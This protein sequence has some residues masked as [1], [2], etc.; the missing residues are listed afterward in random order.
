[1]RHNPSLRQRL[2]SV[3]TLIILFGLL[4]G[5]SPRTAGVSV[6]IDVPLDGLIL[7]GV[8]AINIDGHAAS[9]G[10]ISRIEIWIDGALLANIESP[11]IDDGLATFHLNWTPASIGDYT[12]QAVAFSPDGPPA[13]PIPPGLPLEVWSRM[14]SRCAMLMRWLHRCSFRPPMAL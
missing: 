14:S 8:Q 13:S 4:A 9:P 2:L 7:P 3:F 5:C 11:P 1:M 6:W 12:I 10:G